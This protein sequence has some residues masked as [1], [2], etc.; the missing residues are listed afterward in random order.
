M[1]YLSK[2]AKKLAQAKFKTPQPKSV[3]YNRWTI[4]RHEYCSYLNRVDVA[5]LLED[6]SFVCISS[7][8]DDQLCIEYSHVETDSEMKS[9]IRKEERDLKDWEDAKTAFYAEIPVKIQ[10]AEESEKLKRERF[11]DPEYIQFL[12]LQKK[13]TD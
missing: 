6:A 11:K 13:F 2:E 3:D 10:Q 4:T 1:G 5:K 7:D 12:K 8:Y 9:R